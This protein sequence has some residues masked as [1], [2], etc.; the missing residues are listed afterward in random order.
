MLS[1]RYFVY[2][3]TSALTLVGLVLGLAVNGHFL[4][5]VLVV[6]PLA[7]LGTWDLVQSSHSVLRNYP[8]FESNLSGT[9]FSREE[10]T[11]VYERAKDQEAKLPF[12]TELDVYAE[13]HSWLNHSVAP[14]RPSDET[15]RVTI[16]GPDCTR[17]YSASLYNISAMSFGAISANAIRALN[18]GA[19]KGNFAHDTGEGGISPY[20]REFGGDLIWEIGSG[21]FGCRNPDGTFNADLFAEKAQDDQVK[22]VEIKLS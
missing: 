16:G 1:S 4:W 3:A 9:P 8:V 21:Y 11:L 12:G 2:Y 19:K 22:M 13:E 20:H 14:T 18:Q 17:P 6:G 10:R 7:A 5:L 15:Y